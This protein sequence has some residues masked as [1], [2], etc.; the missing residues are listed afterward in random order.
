VGGWRRLHNA[1]LRNLYTS[2]NIVRVIKSKRTGC[3]GHVAC[4]GD[5]RTAYRVWA[6]KPEGN[7]PLRRSRHRW[8]DNIRMNLR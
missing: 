5:T 3:A 1:E 2:P 4:M 7:R 6:R 8:E